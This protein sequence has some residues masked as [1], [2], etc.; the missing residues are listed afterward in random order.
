MGFITTAYRELPYIVFVISC[1][2]LFGV[3]AIYIITR[4]QRIE[5]GTSWMQFKIVDGI[6]ES[7]IN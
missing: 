2:F 5:A 1:I 6:R 3:H 7:H 4:K